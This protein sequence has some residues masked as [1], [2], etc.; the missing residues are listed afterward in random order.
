M[1]APQGPTEIP[2]M[3]EVTIHFP[4][5]QRDGSYLTYFSLSYSR[6][7]SYQIRYEGNVTE[8]TKIK[9]MTDGVLLKEVQKVSKKYT[10]EIVLVSIC[11]YWNV[12]SN[13]HVTVYC[14][15]GFIIY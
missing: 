8:N 14:I 2:I 9:F 7:V 3:S 15:D 11:T 4:C 10:L 13:Y 1:S 12:I 5:S 6:E